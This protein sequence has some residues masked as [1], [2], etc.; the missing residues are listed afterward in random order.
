MKL[1]DACAGIILA[2][3]LAY[4]TAPALA[5]SPVINASAVPATITIPISAFTYD[6]NNQCFNLTTVVGCSSDGY[7]YAAFSVP[8]TGC[9]TVSQAA[10]L[11][12]GTLPFFA[13]LID[14]VLLDHG[15]DAT[16]SSNYI[17]NVASEASP[18]TA[19]K[20]LYKGNHTYQIGPQ[21]TQSAQINFSPPTLT[22]I[23]G[24]AF[25]VQPAG[26]RDPTVQPF[27]SYS[28]WN[29][30]IG[31]SATWCL[32]TDADCTTLHTLFGVVNGGSFSENICTASTTADP[33]LTMNQVWNGLPSL[34]FPNPPLSGSWNTSCVPANGGDHNLAVYS[35]AHDWIFDG[36]N[37][38]AALLTNPYAVSCSPMVPESVCDGDAGSAL[39]GIPGMMRLSEV[40]AQSYPHQLSYQLSKDALKAPAFAWQVAYPEFIIDGCA[41]GCYSGGSSGIVPGVT[42]G[43]PSTVNLA[44]LGLTTD[45]LAVATALQK[46]GA[47]TRATGGTT[48]FTL[49]CEQAC[50]GGTATTQM[51]NIRG[52]MSKIV[53]VLAIMRN[54][55]STSI[56]GG[57]T[58][59]VAAI[60]RITQS[61]C[62]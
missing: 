33:L 42:I 45:G 1:R 31:S 46:Y 30:S 25:P 50:D 13:I 56:N 54:Q 11:S 16:T 20:C 32:S 21:L 5:F 7:G 47:R 23:A 58:P 37:C 27:A 19:T 55:S 15:T 41:T 18:Y 40:L 49:M 17:W 57:G 29:T 48:Q 12:F 8:V 35:A 51:A 52:D 26:T 22:F 43:I 60:G 3:W 10:N 4:S 34:P 61:I 2:F 38:G 36:Y 14:N 62:P 39:G 9:Y 6:P 59:T 53:A 28:I 44:G 24:S